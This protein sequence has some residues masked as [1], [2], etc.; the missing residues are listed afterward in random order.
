MTKLYLREQE[1]TRRI[2]KKNIPEE[3]TVRIYKKL[4]KR[5]KNE[6]KI[7]NTMIT[8]KTNLQRISK[9]NRYQ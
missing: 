1:H 5:T 4:R 7:F 2:Y 6:K 3:F 8:S 9:K